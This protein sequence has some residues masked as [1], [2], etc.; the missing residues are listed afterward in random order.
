MVGDLP[1]TFIGIARAQERL[2]DESCAMV[3]NQGRSAEFYSVSL[4]GAKCSV[5]RG[6][7]SRSCDNCI[8]FSAI[9]VSG[10]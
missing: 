5:L 10:I 3:A 2:C 6:A 4:Y 1:R 8:T 7:Q 9:E